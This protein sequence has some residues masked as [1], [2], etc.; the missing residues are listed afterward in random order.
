[1]SYSFLN[2]AEL[3]ELCAQSNVVSVPGKAAVGT[4]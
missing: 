3:L 4:N 1:M 2:D